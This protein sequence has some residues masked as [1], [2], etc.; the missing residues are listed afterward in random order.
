[1]SLSPWP[2]HEADE[3]ETSRRVLESGKVNYWTG[4]E[5][6]AFE[7]EF[8]AHCGVTHAIALSNGTL[9]LELALEATE[10]GQGDDV[11]VTPRTFIASAS[12]AI[13][14]G[15]RPVFADV[16]LDSQNITPKSIESALTPHTRAII[17]VHHAGW[18]CDMDGI[19]ALADKHGLIVIE[20]CAQAHGAAYKGRPVG[21]LGH[22]AA[23]S[24]CQDKVMTT[25]GEG[26]MLVTSDESLW[27]RAWSIKDH[28]KDYDLVFNTEHPPGFRWLH[29]SF[30]SNYRMT[31][32]QAAIGRLQ[33]GKLQEWN[34][35]RNRNAS[36]I[37]DAL[38]QFSSIRV[39]VPGDD[40]THG[41]YRLYA[42]I[43][44][45]RLAG[46]WNRD[47]ILLEINEQGIP[48]FIGSCPEIYN[49]TAFENAG[50]KLEAPLQNAAVLGPASLAFLVHPTLTEDDLNRTC[51]VIA[52]VLE[53]ATN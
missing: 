17:A 35:L 32:M 38:S 23:Y 50:L 9:A 31:E 30:G 14:Q 15:A 4:S 36:Q 19:M 52:S 48:C 1:M 39:P 49:E 26:G 53:R 34:K 51:D 44:P 6:K 29:Q 7:S 3:I 37:I 22:V 16:S 45:E 25:G 8:A 46:G 21:S 41:Y 28:G 42:F 12:C 5:C 18:P 13:R 24:F 27:K 2:Y 20:D 11:I 10:I 40:I 47:R 43:V 33:L